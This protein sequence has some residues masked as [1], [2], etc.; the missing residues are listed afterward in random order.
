MITP[1]WAPSTPCSKEPAVAHDLA[2]LV[3]G[4]V[5]A[6]VP[7]VALGVL[8]VPVV[9]LLDRLRR[10]RGR[11]RGPPAPRSRSRSRTCGADLDVDP[12]TRPSRRSR[13]RPSGCRAS[14]ATRGCDLV[15]ELGRVEL[16]RLRALRQ[17]ARR[18]SLIAAHRSR[19]GRQ[20]ERS[21]PIRDVR[22]LIVPSFG[23]L[24]RRAS[25]TAM[26]APMRGPSSGSH[27]ASG[28]SGAR[29]PRRSA[30]LDRRLGRRGPR[31]S[32]GRSPGRGRCRH[33]CGPRRRG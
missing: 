2:V 13:G 19:R 32:P 22:L 12:D 29:S 26:R 10:S 9:G 25:R 14:S 3:L 31:R 21:A 1:A 30:R 17:S 7:D 15:R 33:R 16:D 28:S 5:L 11:R 20:G 8:G 6:Q 24:R 18:L 27:L 23:R 4:G